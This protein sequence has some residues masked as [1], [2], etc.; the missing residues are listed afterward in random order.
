ME[1]TLLLIVPIDVVF[2]CSERIVVA[3]VVVVV[4]VSFDVVVVIAIAIAVAID[5]KYKK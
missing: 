3:G 2:Y 4:L 1:E 5:I